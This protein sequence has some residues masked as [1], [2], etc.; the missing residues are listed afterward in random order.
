MHEPAVFVSPERDILMGYL[1][2]VR[3]K[4]GTERSRQIQFTVYV[5]LAED[6]VSLDTIKHETSP[7]VRM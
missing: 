6:V 7:I 4:E 5:L 1:G 2:G 3:A